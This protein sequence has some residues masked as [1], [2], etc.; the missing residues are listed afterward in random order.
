MNRPIIEGKESG[1]VCQRSRH[2]LLR[3]SQGHFDP[4]G[5]L[6]S[7]YRDMCCPAATPGYTFGTFI[8]TPLTGVYE[9]RMKKIVINGLQYKKRSSGIGVMIRELFAPL[10][11]ITERTCQ[12]ILPQDSP[13]FPVQGTTELRI[14]FAHGENIRR[15]CFQTFLM[16]RRYCEESVLLTTDSKTPFFL[17]RSCILLPIITDLAVFRMPEVYQRSRVLWWRF[18]YRYLCRKAQYFVAISAFTKREL[19]DV[20]GVDP[21]NIYV[22]P[23]AVPAHYDSQ[24]KG[25]AR[26]MQLKR[27]CHLPEHYLLFVG[28]QNP[29]KNLQRLLLAYDKAVGRENFPHH[30][31]I[32]GEQGWKF[33]REACLASIKNK[34]KVHFIGFVSDDDMPALYSGATMFL[35]PT[36]YEGFGIPVLEAQMCGTPVL[37]SNCTSL[38]EV[39]GDAAIYVD[40]YQVED[41]ALAITQALQNPAA[42]QDLIQK[43][44]ENVKRYS[45]VQ[46]AR[47]LNE[48][49]EKV[50]SE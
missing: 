2:D 39:G 34:D 13:G 7:K 6:G 29:R 33:N 48:I 24:S 47:L 22:V 45:W 23:C 32:A 5:W 11:Q 49:I 46:S 19:V 40:P 10:T 36:L 41:I 42:L 30:L 43:G 18:Q 28:N 1:N 27:T 20:L 8:L 31:V 44:F 3:R 4:H 26:L 9:Y 21:K 50:V 37:T 15:I 17:P 16:G 35:F 14:P 38:P 25:T 12:I